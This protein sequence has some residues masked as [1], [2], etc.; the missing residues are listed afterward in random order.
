MRSA[1]VSVCTAAVSVSL[2]ACSADEGPLVNETFSP[3]A[4]A[5]IRIAAPVDEA[6]V[7]HNHG[8]NEVRFDPCARID[9]DTI[10]AA[11]FD[12]STRKRNDFIFDAYSFIG[13][14]FDHKENIRGQILTV[15]SL[16]VWSTNVSLEEFRDRYAKSSESAQVGGRAALQYRS[17]EAHSGSCG[18]VIGFADAVLDV[19]IS[20]NAAFTSER[21]CDRIDQVASTIESA[22]PD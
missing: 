22:L 10:V 14:G 7:Q 5:T 11:G 12:P 17:T 3:S 20:T 2:L 4:T 15:S 9:D 21:P 13:C 6:P 1:L 19:S 16:T 18:M 8:R